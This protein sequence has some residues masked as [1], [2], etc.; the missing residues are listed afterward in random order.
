MPQQQFELDTGN[1]IS[2]VILSIGIA[3]FKEVAGYPVPIEKPLANALDIIDVFL[4]SG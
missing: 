4:P 3:F 1:N 2:P